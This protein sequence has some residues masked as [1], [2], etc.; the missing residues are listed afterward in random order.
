MAFDDY[1]LYYTRAQLAKKLLL[2]AEQAGF[3]FEKAVIKQL[4][5]HDRAFAVA[6]LDDLELEAYASLMKPCGLVVASFTFKEGTHTQDEFATWANKN[7][8]I[9]VC[10]MVMIAN[11][12][13]KPY[14]FAMQEKPP[15]VYLHFFPKV[16]DEPA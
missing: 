11:T 3:I 10:G 13:K 14:I 8:L 9:A 12:M 16:Q 2:S 15:H 6:M 1:T 5:T 7:G 4:V